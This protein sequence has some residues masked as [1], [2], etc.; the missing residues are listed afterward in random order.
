MQ[1][2]KYKVMREHLGDVLYSPAGPND[3]REAPENEVKHLIERG[4]LVEI[5]DEPQPEPEPEPEPQAAPENKAEA[6]PETAD[7]P[8]AGKRG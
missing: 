2:K 1:M 7:K 3:T 4:V 6:A 8:K 5:K